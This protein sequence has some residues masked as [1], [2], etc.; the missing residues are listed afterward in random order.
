MSF[1]KSNN[2]GKYV[3]AG[4]LGL[5]AALLGAAAAAVHLHTERKVEDFQ[6]E[7]FAR[8]DERL[9]DRKCRSN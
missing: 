2:D 1:G 4:G 9:K 6:R 5:I 8:R 3:L 7:S